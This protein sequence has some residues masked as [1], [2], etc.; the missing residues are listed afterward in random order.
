VIATNCPTH[1]VKVMKSFNK[2]IA[3]KPIEKQ[4]AKV[5]KVVAGMSIIDDKLSLLPLEVAFES[6]E[7]K[8]G[9]VIYV[10]GNNAS[11]HQWSKN[12]F[13]LE[14]KSFILVPDTFVLVANVS[15]PVVRWG[16]G[17]TLAFNGQE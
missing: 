16:Y 4:A 3:T 1:T 10:D 7:F 12:V 13:E 11:N 6:G 2:F 17:S 14:G 5:A 9:D 15:V 8:V